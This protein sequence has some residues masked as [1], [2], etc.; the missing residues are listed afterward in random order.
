LVIAA[1]IVICG[2]QFLAVRERRKNTRGSSEGEY[3]DEGK[4]VSE[5]VESVGD[6]KKV[7]VSVRAAGERSELEID[8][9]K[10]GGR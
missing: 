4:E 2:I 3:S 9:E 6:E 7:V 8:V 5:D 1:L 10:K